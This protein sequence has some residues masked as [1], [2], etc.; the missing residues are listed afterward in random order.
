MQYILKK[1]DRTDTFAFT[2]GG[3]CLFVGTVIMLG[4][5]LSILFTAVALGFSFALWLRA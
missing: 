4:V 3:T 5:F 1:W 2:F